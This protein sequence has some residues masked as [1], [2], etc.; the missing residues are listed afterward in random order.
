MVKFAT[1]FVE[2]FDGCMVITP[3]HYYRLVFNTVVA[4]GGAWH[5][6]E[7]SHLPIVSIY[8]SGMEWHIICMLIILTVYC[9]C[10]KLVHFKILIKKCLQ[11]AT[12]CFKALQ[13]R[14]A[15]VYTNYI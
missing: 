6:M 1:F 14:H 5:S 4:Q 2:L 10:E 13:S 9:V 8:G 11:T 7:Q 15:V 12:V 3:G